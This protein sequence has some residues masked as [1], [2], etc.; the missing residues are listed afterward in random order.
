MPLVF[1]CD[2]RYSDKFIHLLN[3]TCILIYNLGIIIR[4]LPPTCIV[5]Y[6]LLTFHLYYILSPAYLPFVLLPT[7]CLPLFPSCPNS[8][9]S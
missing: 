6:L 5:A 7:S 9:T 8:H 1:F 2:V 4:R 3:P